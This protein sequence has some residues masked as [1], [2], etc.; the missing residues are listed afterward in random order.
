MRARYGHGGRVGYEREWR[1][2]P[3]LSG[4]GELI[5]QG[6]HLLDLSYWVF[7]DLPL[8][9]A[10]VRTSFWGMDVDDNAVI[11]LGSADRR[12]PW[13]TFHVSCSEW[14]NEFA[15]ELY[16]R[17]SKFAVTGLAGSYGT[18]TL[19]IY[20]MRPE[21]GP[22]DLEEIPIRPVTCRGGMNGRTCEARS[23]KTPTRARCSET[24][25]RPGMR[26]SA[27]EMRIGSR[28]TRA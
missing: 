18:Q 24:S 8:Q 19:R 15:L 28:A 27:S 7:G 22:P 26:S 16:T 23:S 2:R 12:A 21:M 20:R 10:L 14:K 3:E 4:G 11:T 6:M 9:S 25:A 13:T 1:A 5:D 17:R